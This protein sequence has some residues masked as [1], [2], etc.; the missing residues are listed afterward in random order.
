MSMTP[1]HLAVWHGYEEIALCLAQSGAAN[2]YAQTD[3]N[4]TVFDLAEA[5]ESHSLSELIADIYKN[6]RN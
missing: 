5:N 4:K 2:P 3:D 6:L 1:L